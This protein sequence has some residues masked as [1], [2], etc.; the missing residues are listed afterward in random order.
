MSLNPLIKTDQL[1]SKTENLWETSTIKLV[2]NVSP[3]HENTSKEKKQ[4]AC[5]ACE[6]K[7]PKIAN[8]CLPESTEI[9]F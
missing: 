3:K 9:P 7:H 4:G 8:S 5:H 6:Q 1:H 2:G